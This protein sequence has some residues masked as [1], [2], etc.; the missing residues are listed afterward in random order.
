APVLLE[1]LNP[2]VQ[3]VTDV[4]KAIARHC[5]TVNR[6]AKLLG[7]RRV[8]VV[9]PGIDIVRHVTVGAPVALVLPRGRV[10]DDDAPV[11]IAI[12]NVE[13]I[14]RSVQVHLGWTAEK[15]CPRIPALPICIT[16][17]PSL[18]NLITWYAGT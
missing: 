11:L 2:V 5:H 8:R 15:R 4:D 1:H 12:G 17:V 3:T 14:G 9:R 16:N 13:L 7:E 18:L 10:D 6:R